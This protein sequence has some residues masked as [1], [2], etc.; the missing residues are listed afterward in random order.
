MSEQAFRLFATVPPLTEQERREVA[1]EV[2]R[3]RALLARVP[4]K[5]RVR[6]TANP[7]GPLGEYAALLLDARV[8]G[9]PLPVAL[10]PIVWQR[11]GHC[12]WFATSLNVLDAFAGQLR[13]D[14]R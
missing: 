7:S 5:A 12:P 14:R 10:P 3:M 9:V 6:V 13:R 8:R 4:G 1:D 11:Y 2:A